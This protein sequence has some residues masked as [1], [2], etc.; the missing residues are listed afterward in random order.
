LR[1]WLNEDREGLRLHR[2]LSEAAHDWELLEHDPGALYRG[3]RLSQAN[4]WAAENEQTLSAAQRAY[5]AASNEME[6]HEAAEREAQRQRE[7]QA[8]LKLAATEQQ[9]IRRLRRRNRALAVAGALVTVAAI[10]A[11]ILGGQ[12]NA[13]ATRADQ[14]AAQAQTNLS[15]AQAN[16]AT[17]AAEAQ[18]RATA[19]ANAEAS[20]THAEAQRLAIEATNIMNESRNSITA[21]LLALRSLNLEYTPQGDAALLN[22]INLNYPV[23]ALPGYEKRVSAAGFSPDNQLILDDSEDNTA[24]LFDAQSGQQLQ[25]FSGHTAIVNDIAFSPDRKSILTGSDDKTARLWDTAT[26]QEIQKFV[27]HMGIVITVGFSPDGKQILTGSEDKTLRL[28]DIETGQEL[29]QWFL[30]EP[31]TAFTADGAYAVGYSET[32]NAN[33]VWDTRTLTKTQRFSYS[34]APWRYAT[35]FSSDGK[36]LLAAYGKEIVFSDVTSGQELQ[37]FRGHTDSIKGLDLSPNGKYI[38]SGSADGTARLWD[39]KTGQELRR[40][41]GHGGQVD[42]VAFSSDGQRILTSGFEGRVLLWEIEPHSELPTFNSQNQMY[43][44]VFSPDGKLLATNVISNE[45]RLW[46]V[47]TRQMLWRTQDSGLA[48]W[49]LK[50]SPD[51]KYLLSGNMDGVT[52]LWDAKTGQAVRRFTAHGLDEIFDVAFSPDGKK[53]IAVGFSSA[54]QGPFAPIWNLETG[55]EILR[56]PLLPLVYTVSFSPDGK[57][58]LTGSFDGASLLFDTKTGKKIHEFTGNLGL[59]S[60]DGR[61]AV[62]AQGSTGFVWD[63]QTGQEIQHFEGPA[64]GIGRMFYAPDGKTV[65][66]GNFDGSVRLWDVQT[67]QELRRYLHGATVANNVTFSPD[68]KHIVS[69]ASD[70]VARFFDVDYHTTMAYLCSRLLR[71]FTDDERKQYGIT[72]TTPTCP[73]R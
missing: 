46:D 47:P 25:V 43:G 30:E 61:F 26:G 23:W 2:H 27:G 53:V 41:S 10:I 72:D 12:A 60:P 49:A 71:D 5:L 19:Q 67:G 62:T 16:A 31:V 36:Y 9:A 68:S 4:E 42:V 15:I 45:L 66:A 24:R 59:F 8:A 1:D 20:F 39:V 6:Q 54:S 40:F 64:E 32:G 51:G 63:V 56:I 18:V 28:W 33:Y 29:N 58:V 21:A 69:V 7:L 50:Y 65:A 37:V 57:S 70:G 17:A 14:N 35:R 22:A 34:G 11:I 48:L 13:N 52:T 55:R 73:P 3:A 44:V 38:L